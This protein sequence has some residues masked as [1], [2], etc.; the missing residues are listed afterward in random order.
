MNIRLYYIIMNILD[1]IAL[2][3]EDTN[4]YTGLLDF[5]LGLSGDNI[6]DIADANDCGICNTW[7]D[8]VKGLRE[9]FASGNRI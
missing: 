2:S 3:N 6:E 4:K 9:N 7:D 8:L 5:L 1:S